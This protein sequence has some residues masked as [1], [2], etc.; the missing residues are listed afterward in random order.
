MKLPS[1]ARRAGWNLVDQ[2]ISSGTNAVLSFLVARAVDES[3]FGGFAVAFTVFSLVVGMS[4]A[5]ATSALGIRYSGASK[6]QFD[7]ATAAAAGT[8]LLLGGL[9][10]ACSLVA[11]AVV[12]GPAGQA[13]VALGVVLP[14]L[15]VQDAWRYVFFAAG[16]PAAAALNDA[17]WA[18][19]QLGAVATLLLTGTPAVGSLV[20]AWG[21]AALAAAVLGLRQAR[22]MPRSGR[23]FAWIRDHRDLTGYIT[24]EFATLQ[25]AQQGALLIIA[26]VGSLEA[27]GALRGVQVLLGPTTI[28]A[29][30][31]FSFAIPELARRRDVLTRRQWVTSA[32]LLSGSI[33]ALGFCWGAVFLMLPDA[34][35]FALLGDTWPGVSTIMWPTVVGQVAAAAAVGPAAVFYAM[36]RARV[37]LA[38]HALLAPLLL[39]GG[40]GGVVARGAP[41]AAW[42][43]ALAFWAVL[44]LWWRRLGRHLG[45]L[46]QD[47]TQELSRPD[48]PDEPPGGSTGRN[49]APRSDRGREPDAAVPAPCHR[50][51]GD[52]HPVDPER[53][54]A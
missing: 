52:R 10:G 33:S 15:T 23:V 49:T 14:C 20:L 31:A 37:T 35:G 27:I 4:R 45:R 28:L 2:M 22:I 42:G 50:L 8:A 30:A 21:G 48:S 41:G 3:T 40:V 29:V 51:A 53:A 11:G 39:L 46:A 32:L 1:V 44:P 5:V 6:E 36:D 18:V 25:G 38:I 19:V 7:G 24:A 16:R 54:P 9:A 26:T 43:F 13:L 34:V 12:G 47:R 17:V